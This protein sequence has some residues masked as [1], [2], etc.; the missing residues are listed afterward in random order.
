ML[1][2]ECSEHAK[3]LHLECCLKMGILPV[4]ISTGYFCQFPIACVSVSLSEY[5]ITTP[6]QGIFFSLCVWEDAF[7][8]WLET[9][10]TVLTPLLQW[11][12][13]VWLS[14]ETSWTQ[15]SNVR[16]CVVTTFQYP[17]PHDKLLA[18]LDWVCMAQMVLMRLTHLFP[19][20]GFYSVEQ[21]WNVTE[22]GHTGVSDLR[23]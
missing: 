16:G 3:T 22:L 12:P 2:C 15:G 20:P 1:F 9:G 5:A 18:T 19:F 13:T 14:P 4:V 6:T 7:Y 11:L 8:L 10:L 21:S 23:K 17:L